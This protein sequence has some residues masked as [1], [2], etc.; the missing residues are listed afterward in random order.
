MSE[1]SS[2]QSSYSAKFGEDTSTATLE[3]ETTGA[4]TLLVVDDDRDIRVLIRRLLSRHGYRVLEA[5]DGVEALRVLSE[6]EA[7]VSLVLTD[8]VM[9]NMTGVELGERLIAE[10]PGLP[11]IYLSAYLGEERV[12]QDLQDRGQ[13]VLAKPFSPSMLLAAVRC[14]LEPSPGYLADAPPV[15]DRQSVDRDQTIDRPGHDG[16]TDSPIMYLESWSERSAGAP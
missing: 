4:L 11:V 16:A 10:Y 6:A 1:K 5:F 9:P 3:M 14:V 12:A 8:I 15:E 13:W 2:D 7:P